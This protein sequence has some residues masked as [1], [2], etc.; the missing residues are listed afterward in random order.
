MTEQSVAETVTPA[1]VPLG[2]SPRWRLLLATLGFAVALWIGF[3][4]YLAWTTANPVLLNRAQIAAAD[5]ILAGHWVEPAQGKFVAERSWKQN[6]VSG[7][8]VVRE[9]QPGTAPAEGPILLALT[10][11]QGNEYRITAGELTNPGESDPS[12]NSDRMARVRPLGYPATD[13]LIA[14]LNQQFPGAPQE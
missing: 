5:V 10:R 7:E 1:T 13:A 2:A 9:F 8:I 6:G 14:E 4:G 12:G 3:L 11:I